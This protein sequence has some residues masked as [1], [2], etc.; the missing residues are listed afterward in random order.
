MNRSCSPQRI[1]SGECVGGCL[2]CRRG[3][4]AV[5]AMVV[6]LVT[7]SLLALQVRRVRMQWQQDRQLVVQEQL[8]ILADAALR[9]GERRV[10]KD[11]GWS[12]GNWVVPSGAFHRCESVS[13]EV[14]SNGSEITVQVRSPAEPE[15]AAVCRLTRKVSVSNEQ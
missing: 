13:L 1:V 4:V 2:S 5:V 6:L 7:S 9:E 11:P 10:R 14:R 8:R 15:L 12:G 3:A